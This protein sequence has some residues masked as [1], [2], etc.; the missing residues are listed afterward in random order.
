MRGALLPI[1]P[2]AALPMVVMGDAAGR[3]CS[4]A[5]A[6]AVAESLAGDTPCCPS[7]TPGTIDARPRASAA[8]AT[9]MICLIFTVVLPFFNRILWHQYT[10]YAARSEGGL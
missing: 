9:R 6:Q 2:P 1:T 5:T 3:G 7:L 8:R 10:T 4:F